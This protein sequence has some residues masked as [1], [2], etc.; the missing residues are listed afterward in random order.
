MRPPI[1]DMR[2]RGLTLIEVIIAVVVLGS[3]AALLTSMM[4]ASLTRSYDTVAIV[5]SEVTAEQVLEQIQAD[6]IQLINTSGDTSTT[7]ATM[8]GRINNG[9]YQGAEVMPGFTL[10]TDSNTL[11]SD[12]LAVRVNVNDKVLETYFS[13]TRS[14]TDVLRQMY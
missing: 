4:G 8:Q 14:T 7:I 6:F 9:D 12:A 3:A 11:A 5:D 10:W 2:Q 13:K 1:T